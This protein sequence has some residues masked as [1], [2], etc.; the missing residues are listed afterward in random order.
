MEQIIQDYRN[1]QELL[2]QAKSG[3]DVAKAYKDCHSVKEMPM[4][5]DIDINE[6]CH[7]VLHVI[8]GSLGAII[9]YA[10]SIDPQ[11]FV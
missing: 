7:G 4:T 5:N 10:I 9:E 6:T 11:R 8:A 1:L 3:K 2:H